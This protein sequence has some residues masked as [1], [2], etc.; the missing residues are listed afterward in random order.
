MIADLLLRPQIG[1]L[2]GATWLTSTALMI[3]I[4]TNKT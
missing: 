1:V 3:F 4:H 2:R